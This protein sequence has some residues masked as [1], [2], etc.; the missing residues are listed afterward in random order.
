MLNQS[1]FQ[2]D[3]SAAEVMKKKLSKKVKRKK[4]KT[5]GSADKYDHPS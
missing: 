4:R 1:N 3:N 5:D 2:L